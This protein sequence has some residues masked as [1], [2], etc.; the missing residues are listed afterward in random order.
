[1]IPPSLALILIGIVTEQSRAR[2][3]PPAFAAK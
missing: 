2:G 1:V 3:A